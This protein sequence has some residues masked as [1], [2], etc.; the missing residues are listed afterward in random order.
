MWGLPRASHFLRDLEIPSLRFVVR[1]LHTMHQQVANQRTESLPDY[2]AGYLTHRID[3]QIA[4]F[5][6]QKARARP[7]LK[8]FRAA[9]WMATGIAAVLTTMNAL[10]STLGWAPVTPFE[11]AL[12]FVFFPIVL[13][14]FAA[15]CI[16]VISIN[17]W[18]R[19]VA[20]YREMMEQLTAARTQV[21]DARTWSSL[22]REVQ[23]TERLLLQEVLE[24]HT[25]SRYSD[26]Q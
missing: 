9:F 13:P 21:E 1:S 16:S 7:R 12:G 8:A 17:D 14:V 5:R 2:R 11:E 22:E 3:D 20:R 6:R 23:K 19:R 26:S 24:W 4:Y 15:A 18:Q 25:V 10:H